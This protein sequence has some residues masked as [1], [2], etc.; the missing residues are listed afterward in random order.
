VAEIIF[1]PFSL[2][3][4]ATRLLRDGQ[5]VR[6]RPQALA[7]LRTL[8]RHSGDTVRYEQ[9]IAEAWEGTVVSR[10]TV[11][12][13]VSEVRRSLGEFAPWIVNRPKLGYS[14]E[15]PKSDELVRKGWHF[16]SRRT[17]E[18]FE[19]AID[20][21]EKAASQCP[22][23]FR[24][25]EGL[26]ASHLALAIFGMRP[27]RLMYDLFLQAHDRAIAL[28][29]LTPELRCNRAQGLHMFERRFAEAEAEFQQTMR[30][31]PA[32]GS[33]Y[34][35]LSMLY[36]SLGRSDEALEVLGRGY[37]V[38][39]L[40]PTLAV[41]EINIRYWR[42]EYDTALDAGSKA[43]EL[44][45]YLQVGR[46]MYA[47]VLES[48]GRL[49]EALTQCR[50]AIAMSPEL[51]WLRA[52]E[53]TCLARQGRDAEA[54]AILAQLDALRQSEYV[55]ACYMAVLYE[56]LGQHERAFEELARAREENSAWLYSLEVDPKMDPF[57]K[58]PRFGRLLAELV[59]S[60]RPAAVRSS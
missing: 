13:T 48:V 38:D 3:F 53:A 23:D 11:D 42:R 15:V 33:A 8:L 28:G 55:D 17:R 59:K 24:T 29:G 41:M 54:R 49:E 34:V 56:A 6:L 39:P 1:G 47:Q 51:T 40:L 20:C 43:V 27:P 50:T 60:Y 5:P 52:Q 7:A 58:D 16:Y 30:D 18:G 22:S 2:D 44:H 10:H 57:R 32:L 25:L 36:A 35:R 12:V 31:N 45:P 46:G 21:F 4:S 26:S 37:L 14:L 9:M 19:H